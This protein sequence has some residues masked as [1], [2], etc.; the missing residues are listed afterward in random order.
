MRQ[1]KVKG[2]Y[3]NEKKNK[4]DGVKEHCLCS[5]FKVLSSG[6]WVLGSEFDS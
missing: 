4:M 6:F 1:R 2:C 5:Q 3:N